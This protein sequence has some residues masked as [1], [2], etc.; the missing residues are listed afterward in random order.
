MSIILHLIDIFVGC[1]DEIDVWAL[2]VA[3]P[4]PFRQVSNGVDGD[5]SDVARTHLHY[6]IYSSY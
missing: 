3:Q 6:G 4:P 1:V 2:P 5:L